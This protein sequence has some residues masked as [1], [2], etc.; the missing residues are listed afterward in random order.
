MSNDDSLF[1]LVGKNTLITG[2]TGGFG[3][4]LSK[5]YINYGQN[6][7]ALGRNVEAL[8][9]LKMLGAD[10]I[11][12]DMN[13]TSAI[14]EFAK[15][16]VAFDNIILSHGTHGARPLRMLS[17]EFCQNVIQTNLIS[18]LDLLSNLVRSRKINS[19]GRIILISS[20]SAHMGASTA[21]PY[22]ASKSALEGV[23]RSLAREF[24]RKDVTV[25][26]IAPAA[27]KTP[28]FEGSDSPVLDEKNY[29]LGVGNVQDVANAA[30][31]LSLRGSKYITGESIILDGGSTWLT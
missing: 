5:A 21:V 29:P 8:D 20:I 3:E 25:N 10:C 17:Q 19:P 30:I 7:T 4:E 28:L 1:Q 16:C 18:V 13:N 12:L 26:T 22:A 15:T 27:I 6:V 14:K 24:L 2:A 9:K 11:E 23:M 31:F